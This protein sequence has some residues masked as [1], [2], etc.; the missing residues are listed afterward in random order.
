M[1]NGKVTAYFSGAFGGIVNE[2]D[3]PRHSGMRDMKLA[4]QNASVSWDCRQDYLR[5]K[6]RRECPG[7]PSSF[8]NGDAYTGEWRHGVFGG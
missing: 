2:A 4:M 6:E 3:W 8:Q 5:Y 1:L 7:R